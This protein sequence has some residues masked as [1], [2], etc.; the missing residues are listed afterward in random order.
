MLRVLTIFAVLASS[1]AAYALDCFAGSNQVL[2]LVE[3]SAAVADD[4]QYDFTV[5]FEYAGDR[6][7]RMVKATLNVFD[8]LGNG[9]TGGP[10]DPDLHLRPG[11]NGEQ[12]WRFTGDARITRINPEDVVANICTQSLV[13]DDGTKEEF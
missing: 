6:P 1:P 3:W 5:K 9:L 2:K 7:I 8:V 11:D 13:Y 12:S 4:G 10:L